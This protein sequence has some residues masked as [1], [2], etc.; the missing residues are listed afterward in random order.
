MATTWIL[1]GMLLGSLITSTHEGQEA[2]E[3]RKAMLAKEKNVTALECRA[4]S[5]GFL[6]SITSSSICIA[7]TDGKCR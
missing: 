7:G 2:C 4:A 3:G 1:T 6:S 5:M